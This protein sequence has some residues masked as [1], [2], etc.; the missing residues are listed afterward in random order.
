MQEKYI[1]GRH[2][3]FQF[4]ATKNRDV[5]VIADP[6]NLVV[7]TYTLDHNWVSPVLLTNET[8]RKVLPVGT[9]LAYNPATKKVVPNYTSYGFGVVGALLFSDADCAEGGQDHSGDRVIACSHRGILY[10]DRL[11]DNGTYRV[12]LQATK[13]ALAD[14]IDF[15]KYTSSHP[16]KVWG[17]WGHWDVK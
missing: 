3:H 10:E 8:Y 5:S 13:D 6:K 7:R 1:E 12:V 17:D 16:L 15:V 9:V 14:R 4:K 2:K 11:W